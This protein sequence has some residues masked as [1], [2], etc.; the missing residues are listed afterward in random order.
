MIGVTSQLVAEQVTMERYEQELEELT[1]LAGSLNPATDANEE[2]SMSG[3]AKG[4][5]LPI[6]E[7]R[8]MLYRHWSLYQ[9]MYH[10]TY[11]ATRLAIWKDRGKRRLENLL[12]TIGYLAFHQ[13]ENRERKGQKLSVF[14]VGDR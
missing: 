12:T 3:M 11:I 1:T 2:R 10:S 9:G 5:I 7:F 4:R 13:H 14:G 6:D 8:F